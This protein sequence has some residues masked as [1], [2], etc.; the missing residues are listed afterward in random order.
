MTR[1]LRGQAKLPENVQTR[2]EAVRKE[3]NALR[4]ALERLEK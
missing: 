3:Y 1:T 2:Y 4:K